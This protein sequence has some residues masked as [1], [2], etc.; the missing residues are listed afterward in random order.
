MDTFETN[1]K[2]LSQIPAVQL[3]IN[4]GYEYLSPGEALKER[5]SRTS[6]VLLESILRSQLKKINRIQYR[7]NEYLFSEENIQSAIE[8]LKNIRYDGLLKTNE[9][10][11]DLL[12]L[13]TAMEQTI[14]GNSKSFNLNY[15][16]WRNPERNSFH[17][18]VEYSVQRSRSTETVRPDI[19]LFVNGIP[20]CV[21]EC[22][23]PQVDIGQ[24]VSQSIR[25]QTDEHIPKLFT[26]TQLLLAINKNSAMYATVGSAA[27]LWSIWKEKQTQAGTP[28][29]EKLQEL[30]SKP[31]EKD[32]ISRILTTLN[33]EPEILE[34]ERLVTEQDRS[35][36]S[37]C[38][39]ERL[40]E[41]A[42]KFTIFD[43]G[44]KK[45]ARYQQYF[46]TKSTLKRIKQF[47][48]D[49]SRRGGIIW[50]TQGSGKSLTMVMLA[51]NLALDPEI[52]NPRIV[53][54]T[55]RDDLDK[56]LGNTFAACGLEASRA[57]S[58][59]NLLELI[60]EK[61]SGIITT[62][63]HKFDKAYAAGKYQDV[64]PD[65]FVLVDESHRTQF[66]SFSARMRQMFPNACYLGFTGTPLMKKEKN[67]FTKFGGLLEPHYSITQAVE[68][69]AV[70]PLLYEGRHV[71]MTQNQAAVDMWFE[72]HTQGLTDQQ[73]ADLKRKYARAEML[74]K[75]DQVI[76]MRA[77]DI[78]EH[79]RAN[80]QGTGFKAQLVAPSKPAALRYHNYLNEIGT[81]SSEVVISPPDMRESYDETDD[82]ATDEVVKFWQKMMRRYRSEEEYTKQLINQFKHGS[83]P[84]ILIVVSKLLT[85]F[86]APKNTVLYLCRVLREHT[87]LQAIA[88]VN[89]IHEGKEFGFIV[90]YASIL[91]ELDKALTMYSAFEGFDESDLAGTLSSINREVEKLP[92]RYS[93]LWDLFK[94]VKH[95]Y[96]EEEYELLLADEQLREEFYARLSEY[97]RNLAIALSSDRFLS[98]T[99]EQTLSRYKAD[100]RK[101]QS[102]KNSVKLRYAEAIDYRDYE[103]KI[104]KL[105]DTHIQADEAIR[106]NEP[107]NIFDDKM[108]DQV[109][110]EQG[111]YETKKTTSSR[112]DTIAHAT[113]RV[114]IE[115]MDTDPAFYEKFSKLIQ[116]AIEDFRAK[117]LSDL[118]YLNK[119]TDIRN[120]VVG[121]V[122][123]EVPVHLN[124]N[125]DAMAYYGVIK[126]FIKNHGLGGKELE[127][128]IADT[129]IAIHAI[130]E[131]HNKVN[132]W[133]DE[134]AK[135][136]TENEIDDYLYDELKNGK[137]IDMSSKQMDGIIEKVLLVAKH[138]SYR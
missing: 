110:E 125:E 86:D 48:E 73:K 26:Y 39:P 19:V 52:L 5:Q 27:K 119:V 81:I 124:D 99:D 133:D 61:E 105:L 114:I 21:I 111:I 15:I 126:P 50:H 115:K 36:Y 4:L 17:V 117:R 90:D 60:T 32:I 2:A 101:F 20:F 42:W 47:G 76:Y 66:G 68:D 13:G 102:L 49:G 12:T 83:D 59:R 37:L 64:S 92:G 130:I 80:W 8:K 31:L 136:Q 72:R 35:I 57:T 121:K 6:N 51:R 128:I 22:K 135:K 120:K 131:K 45:I 108:F 138:R 38:R 122:H 89:R 23:A 112:A 118:D 88:R 95:A 97:S 84:E 33:A 14:E 87:L 129:A 109:K 55:D 44:I 1:E 24:A 82:E 77:F 137:N 67:S 62:L 30:V 106:L 3:L 40:L 25:N 53:L 43:A 93:D 63:I 71:E 54:V 78:I 11:Y 18:T 9:M 69:G 127:N 132:F 34:K 56:Q 70:V 7:G 79:Y 46:V 134:D 28:E 29:F 74:N 103:P 16:D 75:A 10:V 100:L 104:K 113:K 98:E 85:G 116:Q 41:L 91:G 65:I 96:D 123:D 58:G 94:T 107:V